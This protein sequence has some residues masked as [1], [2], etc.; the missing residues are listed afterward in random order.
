MRILKNNQQIKELSGSQLQNES[1]L[2]ILS[3]IIHKFNPNTF[4]LLNLKETGR[5]ENANLNLI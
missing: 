1:C 2:K 4:H 3:I 5:T